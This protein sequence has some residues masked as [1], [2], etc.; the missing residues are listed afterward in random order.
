MSGGAPLYLALREHGRTPERARGS[1]GG[2]TRAALPIVAFTMPKQRLWGEQG[3]DQ[4]L[5]S[6]F[7]EQRSRPVR[8]RAARNAAHMQ[9]LIVSRAAN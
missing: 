8:G 9:V 2:S 3:A 6:P 7:Q 4:C 5:K 1:M